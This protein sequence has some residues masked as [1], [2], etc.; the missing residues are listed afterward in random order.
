MGRAPI[1]E[2]EALA[3]LEVLPAAIALRIVRGPHLGA[4]AVLARLR[5][6]A[7]FGVAQVGPDQPGHHAASAFAASTLALSAAMRSAPARWG[8]G[9]FTGSRPSS[10]ASMTCSSASR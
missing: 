6:G 9:S 5:A 2:V 7:D 8:V 3:G 1:L 4:I 10:F